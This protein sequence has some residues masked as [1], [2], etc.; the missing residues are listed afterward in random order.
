MTVQTTTADRTR[1]PVVT[2]KLASTSDEL[3]QCYRAARRRVHGRAAVPVLGGVRRQRLHRQPSHPVCRRRARGARC[4]CAG[5]RRFAKFER[6]VILKRYR[7]HRPVHSLRRMGARSSPRKKGYRQGLPALPAA[8]VADHGDARASARST[9]GSSISPTT[10]TAPFVRD[11]DVGR[12]TRRRVVHR[13]DGAE[14]AGGPARHGGHPGEVD[15]ARRVQS[16]CGLGRTSRRIEGESD[17]E[18][19]VHNRSTARPSPPGSR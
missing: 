11:L 10:N 8:A 16:A 1:P 7:S 14:P 12:R 18:Y 2:I 3:L 9:T 4:G 5:S 15:G 6:G 17:H 19:D 13:S